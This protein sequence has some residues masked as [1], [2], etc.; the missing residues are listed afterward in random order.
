M[1]HNYNSDLLSLLIYAVFQETS[2]KECI[3]MITAKLLF[4]ESY[5]TANHSPG[6]PI[7]CNNMVYLTEICFDILIYYI[8]ETINFLLRKR[9][10]VL[11]S[12]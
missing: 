12:I 9:H 7:M 11:K 6:K 4:E 5:V 10:I 2:K 3:V 8:Q 1:K